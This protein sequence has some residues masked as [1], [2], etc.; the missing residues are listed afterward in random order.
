MTFTSSAQAEKVSIT[1]KLQ[2]PSLEP[3]TNVKIVILNGAD[4]VGTGTSDQTG[5][6]SIFTKLNVGDELKLI[7]KHRDFLPYETLFKIQGD[8]IKKYV[9]DLKLTRL[10]HEHTPNY[11]IYE[12]NETETFKKFQ[13]NSFL[14]LLNENPLICIEFKHFRNPNEPDS[15][16][17]NRIVYFTEYLKLNNTPMDRIII[18]ENIGVLTCESINDCRARTYRTIYSLDGSCE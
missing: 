3:I 18:N 1:G 2:E 9:F 17:Q 10:I 14:I 15:I 7:T 8:S 13:L 6:F 12:L 4:T 11:A 16:G 5:E